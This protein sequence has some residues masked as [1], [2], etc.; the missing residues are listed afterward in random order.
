MLQVFIRELISNASDALE[1]FRYLQ[2]TETEE[3]KKLQETDRQMEIHIATDKQSR[4]LTIQVSFYLFVNVWVC[5][6]NK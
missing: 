1:K 6:L 4:T 2:L 3:S 5:Y